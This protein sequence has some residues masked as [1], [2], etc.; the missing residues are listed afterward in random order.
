MGVPAFFRWVLEK[1]PKCVTNCI[2]QRPVQIEGETHY[3]LLDTTQPN[4]NGFEIDNLYI[5]MNG[6]IHPCAHPEHGE[7]PKT[8]EEM[9]R[10]VM[11]Y[12]DRIVAAVRPRRVLY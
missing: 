11:A 9:Y 4:P 8:E 1:Y 5:D 10:R 12:V 7:A 3:E 6:L 2:E